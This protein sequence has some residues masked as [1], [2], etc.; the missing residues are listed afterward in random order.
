MLYNFWFHRTSLSVELWHLS[1][2]HGSRLGNS[3]DLVTSTIHTSEHVSNKFNVTFAT[4]AP[5]RKHTTYSTFALILKI[6]K[7]ADERPRL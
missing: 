3:N 6:A 2:G 5:K 1:T 7:I 4:A